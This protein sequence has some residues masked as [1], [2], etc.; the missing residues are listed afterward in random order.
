MWIRLLSAAFFASTC[1]LAP[2]NVS[3]DCS[4][5][6]HVANHDFS[7]E[8]AYCWYGPGVLEPYYGSLGEAYDLG[9]G[10]IVCGSFWM[11]QMP[12]YIETTKDAYVWDGGVTREP[13]S[14]LFYLHQFH[15][16]PSPWPEYS[17]VVL[18][19]GVHVDD[20]FTI[21]YWADWADAGFCD[22]FIGG[23]HDEP[24]GN[25]WTCIA[26]GLPWPSGWQ[27]ASVRWPPVRS[28]GIGVYFEDDVTP[29][30]SPTWGTVK[31]LFQ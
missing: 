7:F 8:W 24:G 25:P 2:T 18:E 14:V 5:G 11:T 23:D 17:E 15:C 10:E 22:K 28:W 1:L 27:H 6:E 3:A 31:A 9:S 12:Y 16:G 4:G 29:T 20:E 13:G 21:G 19:L 26:P 30:D